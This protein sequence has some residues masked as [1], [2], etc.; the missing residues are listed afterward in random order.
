MNYIIVNQTFGETET[1]CNWIYSTIEMSISIKYIATIKI[2]KISRSSIEN[3]Y[4]PW[5]KQDNIINVNISWSLI[6]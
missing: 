5:S 2:I 6:Q 1:T 4:I 3:S